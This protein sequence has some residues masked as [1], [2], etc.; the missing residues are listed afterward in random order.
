MNIILADDHQIFRES[1]KLLLGFEEDINVVGEAP[2][3]IGV[4]DVLN[5]G[6]KADILLMDLSMNGMGGVETARIV[7][8]QYPSVRILILT[9]NS[10]RE[11]ILA[12]L[13]AG[14]DG[15]LLK[16]AGKNEVLLAIRAVNN[17]SSY[18]SKEATSVIMNALNNSHKPKKSKESES[19]SERELEI[20][21]LI[22][23]QYSSTEIAKQLYISVR[24][25]DSHRRNMLEKLGLKNSAGLVKYALE[26][27]LI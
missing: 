17:G 22:S 13:E 12:A 1:M 18:Y 24:T 25:V 9:M 4:L 8:Q 10:E 14:V 19:L 20:L 26:K 11:H 27:G 16:S 21:S 2:N 15:Y 3:G 23:K 7:K 6:Q 5:S